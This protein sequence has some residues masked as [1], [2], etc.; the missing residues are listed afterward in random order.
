MKVRTC[1]FCGKEIENKSTYYKVC[2]AVW[3]TSNKYPSYSLIH[4][5]DLC[6][7]CWEHDIKEKNY[8]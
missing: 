2:K 6:S 4:S 1:D 8:Q 3:N 7:G 5:G